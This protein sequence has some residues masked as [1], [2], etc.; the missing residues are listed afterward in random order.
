MIRALL[1]VL[2]IE[3]A[4]VVGIVWTAFVRERPS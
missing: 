2:L 3:I 1:V 4:A